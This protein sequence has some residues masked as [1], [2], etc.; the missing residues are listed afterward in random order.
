MSED[1]TTLKAALQTVSKARPQSLMLHVR[2]LCQANAAIAE[3]LLSISQSSN[4]HVV[5]VE[6]EAERAVVS[7]D[8]DVSD[9]RT[10]GQEENA[11]QKTHNMLQKHMS[12]RDRSEHVVMKLAQH[13]VYGKVTGS[14]SRTFGDADE[15]RLLIDLR[16]A[17][18]SSTPSMLALLRGIKRKRSINGS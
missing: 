5:G 2:E 8:A 14:S 10:Q 17:I 15:H 16:Q 4:Y 1:L 11:V 9:L 13:W 18:L 12:W 3:A 7:E 6:T